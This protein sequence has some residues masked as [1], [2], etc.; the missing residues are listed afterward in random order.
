MTVRKPKLKFHE[1]AEEP[2]KLCLDLGCGLG[3]HT[4]EGHIGVDCIGTDKAGKR[5]PAVKVVFDLGGPTRWPWKI[6]SV[7]EVN[8]A[9]MLHY[10]TPQQRVFFFNELHR[11][12]KPGAKAFIV[13]PMWSSNRAYIDLLAQWPPVAEG[14]YHTLQKAWREAQNSVDRSGLKCDF[15]VSGGYNMHPA[16][17]ARNDD[18]RQEALYWNK[19]AAQDL[20]MTVI[21]REPEEKAAPKK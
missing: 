14:F 3:A 18:F 6:N 10:L 20:I 2:K 17:M 8:C 16:L 13:T 15:D 7:D 5:I 11:V 19:E 9:M 1:V 12:M 21:K 4:P